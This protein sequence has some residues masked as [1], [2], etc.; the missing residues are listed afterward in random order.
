MDANKE[1]KLEQY[2]EKVEKYVC[3]LCNF[4]TEERQEML[5]HMDFNHMKYVAEKNASRYRTPCDCTFKFRD[6]AETHLALQKELCG[7]YLDYG[8]NTIYVV[9]HA[10]VEDTLVW[11]GWTIHPMGI[12]ETVS[13]DFKYIWDMD[14]TDST[15]YMLFLKDGVDSIS[16]EMFWSKFTTQF[17]GIRE[18]I[19]ETINSIR[20]NRG[21]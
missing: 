20:G 5:H 12:E 9:S 1:V 11:D 21:N 15:K 2:K 14:T 13:Q 6:D 18:C 19:G 3:V 8:E 7:I 16:T 10:S 4:E 17:Q